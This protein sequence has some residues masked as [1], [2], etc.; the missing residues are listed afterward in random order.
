M[1][2]DHF[3][4]VYFGESR[5]IAYADFGS[6]GSNVYVGGAVDNCYRSDHDN[7][8]WHLAINRITPNGLNERQT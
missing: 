2:F 7:E 8:C 3:Q 6:G 4:T 5:A 1:E